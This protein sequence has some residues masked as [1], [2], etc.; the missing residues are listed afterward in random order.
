MRRI[1]EDVECDAN[2]SSSSQSVS[3]QS[4]DRRGHGRGRGRGRGRPKSTNLNEA[5][6]DL[7]L[8]K[9]VDM[10]KEDL[11]N[12][13]KY[14]PI[15][16]EDAEQECE[17]I[18]FETYRV[19]QKLKV[20]TNFEEAIILDLYNSM[21]PIY[22]S[23][24]RGRGVKPKISLL[25]SLF[26]LLCLYKSAM[27]MEY[28][29]AI[30]HVPLTTFRDTVCRTRPILHEV[31]EGRWNTKPRPQVI[32]SPTL[33]HAALVVDSTSFEVYRP[34]GRFDE[35]KIYFD[36]KNH[37]YALKKEVAVQAK[38]PHYAL[39]YHKAT[40]GSVH[41]YETLKKTYKTY[42]DFTKKNK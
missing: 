32:D 29:A 27:Q 30:L 35:A 8:Q 19:T 12:M 10:E 38:A 37:I 34:V 9:L 22:Y 40:P 36:V 3:S 26:I 16:E 18:I 1:I 41:D 24:Y 31:L 14:E 39:F 25:D 23:S 15:V 7:L 28:M 4:V 5:N 11:V 20:L 33:F 17:S 13:E 42:I 2:E 21:V 6:T